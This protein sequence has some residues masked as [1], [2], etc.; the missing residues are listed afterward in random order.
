MTTQGKPYTK[1][2]F[3][4]W[5]RSQCDTAGL[6]HCA[7]HGLRKA[8]ATRFAEAGVTTH[9]LI[10]WIGWKDIREAERYTKAANQQR[11]ARQASVQLIS[12][13]LIGKP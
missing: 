10:A 13:T 3:G 6:P 5:F 11:L 2:Y 7:A 9:Q 4:N 1:E 12:G 8:A